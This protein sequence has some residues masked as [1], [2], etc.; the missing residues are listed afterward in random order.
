MLPSL[1]DAINSSNSDMR[2][3]SLRMVSEMAALFFGK[4]AAAI[5]SNLVNS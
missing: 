5:E 2:V 3:E 1:M 4:R